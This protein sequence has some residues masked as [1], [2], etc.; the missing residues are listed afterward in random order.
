MPISIAC[1]LLQG[2]EWVLEELTP[3][4][5]NKTGW[6]NGSREKYSTNTKQWQFSYQREANGFLDRLQTWAR[7]GLSSTETSPPPLSTLGFVSHLRFRW[8]Q[9]HT[10]MYI[11]VCGIEVV[12]FGERDSMAALYVNKQGG[13]WERPGPGRRGVTRGPL[14]HKGLSR[15]RWKALIADWTCWFV[16]LHCWAANG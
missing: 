16:A 13:I 8:F 14:H 15:N 6:E 3:G 4:Q 5:K 10:S 2:R 1:S 7:Q 9:M 12:V 11:L